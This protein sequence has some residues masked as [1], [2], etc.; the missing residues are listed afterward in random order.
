[1]AVV[2]AI[3]IAVAV[4]GAVAVAFSKRAFTKVKRTLL[5]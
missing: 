3:A 4:T 5:R 2:V 1:M